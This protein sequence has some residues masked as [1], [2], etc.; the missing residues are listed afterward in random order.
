MTPAPA[1][2]GNVS[3]RGLALEPWRFV[4]K[5]V[6]VVGNFRGRNLF[7]DLPG[8]PNQGPYDFVIKATDGAV[9]VT[10]QRPRGRGFDLDVDRRIDSNRWLEVT[11]TVVI[12]RGLV[13]IAV[14][15]LATTM[16]P[17]EAPSPD[18]AEA[19]TPVL[20]PAPLEVV[21]FSPSDGEVDVNPTSPVR[22]QFS[23]GLTEST[24]AGRVQASYQGAAEGS[25]LAVKTVYDAANRAI[26]I[27]FNAPLEPYRTVSVRLL[28]GIKAFDNGALKPWAI[29]F[30]VGGK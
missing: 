15:R 7:G 3:V 19:A 2:T 9:W 5:T 11:G 20:P 26:E 4:G 6:T 28:D 21:F 10:G 25:M 12:D 23:R 27:R 8:A 30:S 24:L 14:T 29:T 18:V 13:R 16:A 22:I 1:A 17:S